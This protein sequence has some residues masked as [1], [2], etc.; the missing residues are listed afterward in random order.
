MQ[1]FSGFRSLSPSY[2]VLVQCEFFCPSHL[3]FGDACIFSLSLSYDPLPL[4]NLASHNLEGGKGYFNF[5]TRDR[6][7]FCP[8]NMKWLIFFLVNCN[9]HSSREAWFS[10]IIFRETRNKRNKWYCVTVTSLFM[11]VATTW[12]VWF[13]VTFGRPSFHPLSRP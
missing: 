2:A 1:T 10:K 12:L 11:P 5:V 6:P 9:F 4:Q 13:S 7:L 8:W 3:P